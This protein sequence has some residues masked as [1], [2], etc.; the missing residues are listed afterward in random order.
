MVRKYTYAEVKRMFEDAGCTL[1]SKEYVNSNTP[2]E[3]YC[4][5]GGSIVQF[6]KLNSF[7][8]GCRCPSCKDKRTNDTMMKR[9]GVSH[10]SKIEEK[11]EAMLKG[12][13]EHATKKKHTVKELQEYFQKE[14]C[15][16]LSTDY[17]DNKTKL[18]V[19]FECG[20]MGQIT[21]NKFEKGQRCNNN[22]CM[23][24]KK[25]ETSL[26]RFGTKWY[27]QTDE[28]KERHK[29]TCIDKYGVDHYRKTQE[30]EDRVKQTCK[31]RYGVDYYF[32][33]DD[34]KGKVKQRCMDDFGVEYY[35]QVDEVKGKIIE[36]NIER[37]GVPVSSQCL[38]VKDKMMN[39]NMERYGVPFT[40]MDDGI[41][42]KAK[43]K[44]FDIYGVDNVS[45]SHIVKEKKI[46]T[47]ILRYGVNHPMQHHEILERSKK[48]AYASKD[49]V[50]PSGRVLK[51][52]GYENFAIDMLLKTYDEKDIV[53]D[54]Q[55]M[56]EFWYHGSD[57][58]Y[59]R[60]YPDIFIKKDNLII[61]VKSPYTFNLNRYKIGVTGNI[62]H[63][64]FNFGC[65]IRM[66]KESKCY[67]QL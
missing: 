63:I 19:Q 67:K 7:L 58:R 36:S 30:C 39:T 4:S 24:R 51:V 62:R 13:R 40:M 22:E 66:G 50:L 12:V 23:N 29:Q 3:F 55:E 15:I 48:N 32:Q 64:T 27:M 33:S 61:E 53:V 44:I 2:L 57:G 16:L 59:H 25:V 41:L 35:A 14:G 17:K 10:I 49:Y 47:S 9:Y 20:C 31:E 5:C 43:Q 38:E 28:Y 65:L 60:Y 46:S 21:F 6:I 52:Q 8:K 37:Y 11:K 18:D 1:V 45:K 54:T 42:A 26:E 34:F 56:P